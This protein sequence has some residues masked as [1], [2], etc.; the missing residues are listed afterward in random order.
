[1]SHRH[2]PVGLD[3]VVQYYIEQEHEYVLKFETVSFLGKQGD[4]LT[5]ESWLISILIDL[6]INF[7]ICQ[8][9][10]FKWKAGLR[11]HGPVYYLEG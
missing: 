1:M 10:T 4:F 11:R 9:M 6:N 3:L 5:T 8:D 7:I 2:Q